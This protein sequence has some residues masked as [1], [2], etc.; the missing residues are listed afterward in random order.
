[1]LVDD[2]GRA[3][4]E[5][6]M[7]LN[8]LIRRAEHAKDL[9]AGDPEAIAELGVGLGM[10]ELGFAYTIQKKY[11]REAGT[12]LQARRQTTLRRSLAAMSLPRPKPD[13][14]GSVKVFID[15]PASSELSCVASI[16]LALQNPLGGG[17]PDK[18]I[19]AH[20][21]HSLV[22]KPDFIAVLLPSF[23]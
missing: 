21:R 13:D 5:S 9:R 6:L 7:I 12:A 2:K 20:L 11:C 16:C 14:R 23:C 15:H 1:M 18:S 19:D 10:M 4:S 8:R 22:T 3:F 17:R